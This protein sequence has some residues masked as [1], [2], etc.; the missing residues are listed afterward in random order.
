M[1][2]T[3]AAISGNK[4]GQEPG[5]IE[6][7]KSNG[8]RGNTQA[9][10]GAGSGLF[11]TVEEMGPKLKRN[12]E[13]NGCKKDSLHSAG[14]QDAQRAKESHNERRRQGRAQAP[15][16]ILHCSERPRSGREHSS[17]VAGPFSHG[18][19]HRCLFGCAACSSAKPAGFLRSTR[20]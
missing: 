15:D 6:S 18:H 11:F 16:G 8:R 1:P 20:S 7:G 17:F 14:L 9:A 4:R 12:V 19:W 5:K 13:K 3:H 10:E 2:A